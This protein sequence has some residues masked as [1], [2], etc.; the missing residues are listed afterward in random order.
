VPHKV[1]TFTLHALRYIRYRE[2]W[3][4]CLEEEPS[5][6]HGTRLE[7]SMDVE[8]GAQLAEVHTLRV[9]VHPDLRLGA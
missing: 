5:T 2:V 8:R 7:Q 3:M 1:P 9:H 6:L 4:W